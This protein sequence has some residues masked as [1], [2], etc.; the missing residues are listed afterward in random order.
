MQVNVPLNKH[1]RPIH[2]RKINA[3]V[4][5]FNYLGVSFEQIEKNVN[6]PL[7]KKLNVFR[8]RHNFSRIKAVENEKIN[9]QILEDSFFNAGL[10]ENEIAAHGDHPLNVV[11]T[12]NSRFK[13]R[14]VVA[15]DG[16]NFGGI[17]FFPH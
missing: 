13:Y 15:Y 6:Q 11:N 17:C 8:L 7:K 5:N 12:E 4:P 9:A 14:L 16:T 1:I 2:L 3:V 10:C